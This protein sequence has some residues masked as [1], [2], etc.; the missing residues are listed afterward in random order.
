MFT[1]T[2]SET[3]EKPASLEFGETVIH[4]DIP[5]TVNGMGCGGPPFDTLTVSEV[6]FPALSVVE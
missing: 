6:G 1:L 4:E 3:A 2:V 5:L